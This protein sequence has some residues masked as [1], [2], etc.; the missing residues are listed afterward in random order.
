M[1]SAFDSPCLLHI[2]AVDSDQVA[3]KSSPT[4]RPLIFYE[5][6]QGVLV[7]LNCF[8]IFITQITKGLMNSIALYRKETRDMGSSLIQPNREVLGVKHCCLQ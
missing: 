1:G 3:G 5:L 2:H 8:L 7:H 4:V 6:R